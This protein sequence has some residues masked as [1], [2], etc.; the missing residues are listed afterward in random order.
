MWGLKAFNP[1][2]FLNLSNSR[3]LKFRLYRHSQI[4]KYYGITIIRLFY[5]LFSEMRLD[6]LLQYYSLISSLFEY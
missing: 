1:A 4:P 5:Q 6:L 3:G 2:S